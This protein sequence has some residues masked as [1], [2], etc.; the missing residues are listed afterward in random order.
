MVQ[1]GGGGKKNSRE[2]VPNFPKLSTSRDI[3]WN[4]ELV[5]I[6]KTQGG[7]NHSAI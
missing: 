7:S 5:A 4:I 2:H 3:I 6:L 1:E